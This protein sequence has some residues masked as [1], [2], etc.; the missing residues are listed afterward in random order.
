MNWKMSIRNSNG[1]AVV[2]AKI[3]SALF[4]A[5]IPAVTSAA[6][7]TVAVEQG[8]QIQ[9]DRDSIADGQGAIM[10]A[11]GRIVLDR[12]ITD[13]KT[14]A[15]YRIIEIESRYDC[16]ERTYA[17]LKRIYYREEGELVREEEV[18]SPFE[19]PV[20]T[21]TPDYRLFREA[22]RPKGAAAEPQNVNSTLDKIN[23]V[24]GDL[25][26]A[27]EALVDKAVREDLQRLT[28]QTAPTSKG[29]TSSAAR[30]PTQPAP[31]ATWSYEGD[32]NPSLWGRLRP[33][34]SACAT[35][36][37]Q[38]PINL[39]NGIAVDL[40]PIQFFYQPSAY[41]VIDSVRQLQLAIYGGGLMV[42]GKQYRLTR[43][44][45]H[46]PAEFTVNG[47]SFDMEAQLLHQADD[48]KTAI[49][50]VLLEQGAENPVIQAA[51]N[52]LPLESGGEV[53]PP[54]QSIDVSLLLPASKDY[55]TFMGSLTQPPCTEDVLWMVL[56][57]PQQVSSD[58]L[59]ILQRLYRPNAR[60]VQPAF[61]RIIKESR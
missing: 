56:K 25:R 9:I 39:R 34:Y 17:T 35:G 46:H 33:E 61:G 10:T 11:R 60:P 48:G 16:A 52:N 7:Q 1:S 21:G 8:K 23:E 2:S 6:W 57:Q 47:Q 29:K 40:E 42:M 20:R 55:Y 31:K 3:L 58:Q 32:G 28:R 59:S 38:S 4:A 15:A 51:L 14:S 30:A 5:A 41:R 54:G 27:N 49:V 36:R 24:A 45:L 43:I 13:P 53:A 50:S 44:H 22:C 19:M 18:R 26:K 37:R 12:P